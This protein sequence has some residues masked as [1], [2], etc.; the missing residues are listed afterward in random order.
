MH[1]SHRVPFVT[2]IRA[3]PVRPLL[4]ARA[5]AANPPGW[6]AIFVKAFAMVARDQPALRTLYVKWPRPTLYEL[7]RSVAMLTIARTEGDED[8]VLLERITAPDEIP[9]AEVDAMIR[10][11]KEAPADEVPAFRKM[12]AVTRLPLPLRRLLW[13]IGLN[14]GRHR[15]KFFGSFGVTSVAAFG[16][17]QLH[18]LSPG[19]F[20][21][22]YGM[23]GSDQTVEVVLRWDHR[24][25]D[26]APMAVA[27]NRLEQV[28]NDE[29]AAEIRADRS[30]G[31]PKQ[32]RAIRT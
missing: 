32:V 20:V 25:T 23:V 18:A 14:L 31:E 24:V 22:S 16:P 9:L 10:H 5:Q 3:V 13:T 7:P 4:E 28:L 1:A 2:L 30:Q 15:A 21:L 8:C 17:G 26:A 12:L 27:L 11:A 29:I 19:P 6:A